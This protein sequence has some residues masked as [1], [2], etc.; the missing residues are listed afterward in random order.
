MGK[1]IVALTT[2][3]LAGLLLASGCTAGE[4]G[5]GK[6]VELKDLRDK[7][8]YS[9][10][11]NIGRDFQRQE[12]DIDA[13]LL[14]KGI[15]DGVSGAEP[16]LTDEQ[17]QETIIAYQQ[18]MMAKQEK[19]IKDLAEKNKKEGEAFLAQNAQ[20]EDV[21][22]R[23][24]GLQYRILQEG[25]G[26]QPT[27]QDIVSVHYE[28]RLVDGTVFD[29]SIERNE[30]AVFPLQG[31]IPGWTEALQLMSK[32]AKWEIVLP[33]ELAYGERGAGPVIGP[34]AVLI[35]EVELLDINPEE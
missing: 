31:V 34:N 35:F 13:D 25:S 5:V 10:G 29:S 26:P 9:I 16:L 1:P 22:T 14:A 3:L 12:M 21:V 6:N 30:P 20:K 11:L 2:T 8:S 32:G 15:K 23:P 24:S 28:G 33:A 19:M 17:M 27:A 18:E 7:V 4:K